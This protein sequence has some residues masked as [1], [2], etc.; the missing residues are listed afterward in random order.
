MPLHIN[1]T[2]SCTYFCHGISLDIV[3]A[4]LCSTFEPFR[5]IIFS[6]F[7]YSFLSCSCT[8]CT[9]RNKEIS[10]PVTTSDLWHCILTS[11]GFLMTWSM[12]QPVCMFMAETYA[13]LPQNFFLCSCYACHPL[14]I[15]IGHLFKIV[16]ECFQWND[17]K[18]YFETLTLCWPHTCG[19]AIIQAE[20][21]VVPM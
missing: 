3:R 1:I 5:S 19:G 2:T 10:Y 17:N 6:A 8:P 14:S 7:L 16:F 4:I 18:K 9:K 11:G 20:V 12:C 21:F 15:W 13:H